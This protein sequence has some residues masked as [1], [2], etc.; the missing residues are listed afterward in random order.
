MA[1]I[2][3]HPAVARRLNSKV[4]QR[5]GE[6]RHIGLLLRNV[7][8]R[9]VRVVSFCV[10]RRVWQVH[11]VALDLYGEVEPFTKP[12]FSRYVPLSRARP[13]LPA[14]LDVGVAKG[15]HVDPAS[16]FVDAIEFAHELELGATLGRPAVAAKQSLYERDPVKF[17]QFVALGLAIIVI[18]LLARNL[19]AH[20]R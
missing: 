11:E 8:V 18:V 1:D 20:L 15:V 13:D 19:P 10:R 9:V 14:W 2:E 12:R 16:R 7:G 6:L 17:W 5:E 4:A 3:I